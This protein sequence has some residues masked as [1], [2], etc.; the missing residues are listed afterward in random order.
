MVTSRQLPVNSK[1][2]AIE[3]INQNLEK[4]LV[5]LLRAAHC[6]LKLPTDFTV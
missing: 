1:Q 3:N 2:F 4:L 6:Q 5:E